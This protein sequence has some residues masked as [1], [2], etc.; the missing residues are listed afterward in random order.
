MK[1]EQLIKEL[2]AIDKILERDF[3]SVEDKIYLINR[4]LEILDEIAH[5]NMANTTRF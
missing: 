2:N 1:T 5:K 4:K 3:S